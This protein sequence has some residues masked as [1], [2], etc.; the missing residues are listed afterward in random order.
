MSRYSSSIVY[1]EMGC[2]SSCLKGSDGA[3]KS[4]EMTAT[5]GGNLGSGGK[6]MKIS[7]SM[8]APTIEIQEDLKTVRNDKTLHAE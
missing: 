5:N 1:C 6:S 7:R 4:T 3:S 8:T 2:C